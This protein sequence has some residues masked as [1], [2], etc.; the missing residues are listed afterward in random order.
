MSA[1]VANPDLPPYPPERFLSAPFPERVR[2]VCRQWASQVNP[3]PPS[4][5]A[6]YWAKY[7]L[8]Y[9]GGWAFFVSFDASYP[10]FLSPLE[11]A[12]T[13]TAFQKAVAWSIFYELAGLGCGWGPMN[14]RFKPP[15]G[16]FRHFLRP[17]TTKLPLVPGP[18]RARRHPAHLARRRALRREPAVP[19]ARARRARAHAR[20]A[21]AERRADPADG[22]ADKT[23]FLAA[24][25]EHY[26][27]ALVC[28]ACRDGGRALDLG[29]Q[30]GLVLHLVLGGDVE[31]QPS[32]PV[33]D[34]GDDEQRAV[35]PEVAEA[36]PVRVAFPTI[37]GRRALAVGMARMGT[38]TEYAIPFVLAANEQPARHGG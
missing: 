9:I 30:A 6:L 7:L 28:I 8:V 34:H 21:A 26:Y 32:L 33:R 29:L 25:A 35:L 2:L 22:R 19:A 17:G 15:F 16:G 11:W 14:G 10:G 4:V 3:T 24:R 37:C 27:V 5:M 36:A 23:L 13:G 20:A 12:F 31:D 18:A 1:S 38:L